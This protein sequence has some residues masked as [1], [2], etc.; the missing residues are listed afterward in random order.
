[1]AR[2]R[3]TAERSQSKRVTFGRRRAARHARR[4]KVIHFDG[5]R[6]SGNLWRQLKPAA[7]ERGTDQ[8][9]QEARQVP[10]RSTTTNRTNVQRDH[11]QHSVACC[12]GGNRSAGEP[13]GYGSGR[14]R[15]GSRPGGSGPSL[16]HVQCSGLIASPGTAG[17]G[18]RT[19]G[20]QPWRG[21]RRVLMAGDR[22]G[23]PRGACAAA[24]PAPRA[25]MAVAKATTRQ[26]GRWT[27]RAWMAVE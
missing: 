12:A 19:R 8:Q 6:P 16:T 18:Q 1:M 10:A 26:F 23:D 5:G 13:R 25:L 20:V 14:A 9:T 2:T 7:R 11:A 3:Q 27:L 22:G 21:Q 4:A 24:H 15:P 17:S